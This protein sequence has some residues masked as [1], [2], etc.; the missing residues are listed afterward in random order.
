MIKCLKNYFPELYSRYYLE[1][2][3]ILYTDYGT[4]RMS[5]NAIQNGYIVNSFYGKHYR[6]DMKRHWLVAKL[7]LPAPTNEQSQINHI[8]GNK[9]NNSALNLEWCTSKENIDH[10]WAHNLA[11]ARHGKEI[12]FTKLT[13]KQVLEIVELLKDGMKQKDIAKLYNVHKATISEI[14]LGHNWAWLTNSG[15]VFNDYPERE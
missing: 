15:K 12:N 3:G 2:T 5:D 10:A 7:F 1:D 11:H 4:K 6:K 8:D 13:E 9:L 14:K